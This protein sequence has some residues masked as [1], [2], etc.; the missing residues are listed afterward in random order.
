MI[1]CRGAFVR[2]MLRLGV[3]WRVEDRAKRCDHA[4]VELDAGVGLDSTFALRLS[5][6]GRYSVNVLP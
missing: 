3:G 5:S 4:G 6:K 1:G 2:L